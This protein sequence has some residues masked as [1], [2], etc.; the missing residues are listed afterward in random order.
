MEDSIC[1]R[2]KHILQVKKISITAL[3]RN[4]GV[5]QS[6]LNR[7]IKGDSQLSA[8]TINAILQNFPDVSSEWLL[9]GEG[10]VF[11]KNN[12]PGG[13]N[14]NYNGTFSEPVGVIVGGGRIGNDNNPCKQDPMGDELTKLIN[15]NVKLQIE[16]DHLKMTLKL[17]EDIIREKDAI[18]EMKNER[19]EMLT[20]KRHLP[21]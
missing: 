1:Q 5:V 11:K 15:E 13:I 14:A 19:I 10:P 20:E 21:K 3:S 12:L 16:N 2:I 7:Q 4:I 9:T 18:I 8:T 17:K 6:T